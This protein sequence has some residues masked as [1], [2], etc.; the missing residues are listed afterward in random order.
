[1]IEIDRA[2]ATDA[3]FYEETN[4]KFQRFVKDV[5]GN[6]EAWGSFSDICNLSEETKVSSFNISCGY[7]NAH[8]TDE[9][10]VMEELEACIGKVIDLLKADKND[11]QKFVYEPDTYYHYGNTYN[12]YGFGWGQ[13]PEYEVEFS[14][15]DNK[16]GNEESDIASGTS[17]EDCVGQFLILHSDLCWNDI[18]DYEEYSFGS[19]KYKYF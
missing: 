9:Y 1:M 12:G 7:Y 19:K 11:E 18:I 2:H 17:F 10:V 16:T 6:E 14:Y 15:Y 8:T 13:D 5:T 4:A 3:V